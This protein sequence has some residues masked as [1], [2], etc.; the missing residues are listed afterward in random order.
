MMDLHHH[1]KCWSLLHL[2]LLRSMTLLWKRR[3]S[4][5]RL[6]ASTARFR[7]SVP[8]LELDR[9]T[10]DHPEDRKSC[11][12]GSRRCDNAWRGGSRE[13]RL[14][15]EF[16]CSLGQRR[17]ACRAR[18]HDPACGAPAD[19]AGL[20]GEAWAPAILTDPALADIYLPDF[21]YAGYHWGEEPPPYPPPTLDVTDFGALADDGEDD[22][23][24]LSRP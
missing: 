10:S 22:S 17:R 7:G 4:S 2:R 13:S 21:S 14:S 23:A 8:Q 15:G 5:G 12:E 20:G 11:P 24:A 6:A 3:V 1:Q 16:Q 9:S 19:R 18:Y